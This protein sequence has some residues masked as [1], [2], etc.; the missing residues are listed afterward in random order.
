MERVGLSS[1]YENERP[2]ALHAQLAVQMPAELHAPL[3]TTRGCISEN[4]PHSSAL[5][6]S[7]LPP[8]NRRPENSVNFLKQYTQA[9][10]TASFCTA[11]S[12]TASWAG[13]TQDLSNT[14]RRP[15]TPSDRPAPR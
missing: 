14:G 2:E 3:A 9:L 15:A 8:L 1:S 4:V 12:G 10:C 6:L 5:S 13:T 7:R 11:T